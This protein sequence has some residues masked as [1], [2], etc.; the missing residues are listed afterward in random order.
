MIAGL[1][2]LQ[3]KAEAEISA[4]RTE[5]DLFEVKTRYLGRKGL[6][7][8]LLRNIGHVPVEERP[9]FGKRGNEIKEVLTERIEIALAGIKVA[10]KDDTLSK[11]KIDVTLEGRRIRPGKLHPITQ[12]KDEI[13]SIFFSFGFS[14][15]EGPEVELDYYNFEALNIPKDHP[16]RDMQ[17]TFYIED[18]IVLR[19]HTSPVQIRTMLKQAPPVR[20]LSPGRVYRPDSDISHTPMFHQIEGL[21]VDKG[22]SFAD[23]KGILTVF[24][25]ELFGAETALRFRPSFFPFTEPS[26]E[27][28]IQCVICRGEGCRV[29]AQTGWLE[30]LGSG[31]VDPEVFKNVGYDPEEYTGFA[32]GL[33]IERIAMLK[34]GI[35]DIRLFFENDWRFLEQF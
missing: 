9:L 34:Y 1:E 11:G 5:K 31:M 2:D 35:S 12:V 6:L 15:V 28:D 32:F 19:T 25:Q 30:I 20:I 21:L 17:D 8:G 24:L 4:A 14:I 13:C 3:K 7:T 27:V 10:E 29:C 16:A 33:G 18:N 22:I 23:L 26:A